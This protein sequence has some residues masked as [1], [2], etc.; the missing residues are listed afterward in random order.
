MQQLCMKCIL[1]L[2]TYSLQIKI[3]LEGMDGETGCNG[4][5]PFVVGVSFIKV[6]RYKV[7]RG[8]KYFVSE[9]YLMEKDFVLDQ[10]LMFLLF[11]RL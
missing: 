1:F 5:I 3:P 7:I 11:C 9:T 4:Y 8:S 6:N 2:A 10:Y